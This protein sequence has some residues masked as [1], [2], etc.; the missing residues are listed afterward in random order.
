MKQTITCINCPIGCRMTVETNGDEIVNIDGASC[1]RGADY[2]KQEAVSPRRMVT[3]VVN[4]PSCQ[5][6]LSVKT[7]SP[8][9][10]DRIFDCMRAIGNAELKTPIRMGE[11]V[12]E[13]VCGTGVNVV[14]TRDLP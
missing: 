2:A 11:V 13:N 7:E 10:K 1:K 12:C 9:P 3:A 5:T 8:I 14:S 6:P 4:V